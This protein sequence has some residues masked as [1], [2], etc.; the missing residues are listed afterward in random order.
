MNHSIDQ[1]R[2]G[3]WDPAN[4]NK[5]GVS[6]LVYGGNQ[7]AV[8][9][10]KNALVAVKKSSMLQVPDRKQPTSPR[11][12]PVY[13][14]VRIPIKEDRF[15]IYSR[16]FAFPSNHGAASDSDYPLHSALILFNIALAHHL[17]AQGQ[18]GDRSLRDAAYFYT[19]SLQI[20]G[21]VEL[22]CGKS[23]VAPIK[24][25]ALNNLA[26]IHY[27]QGSARKAHAILTETYEFLSP[28]V[29]G[30]HGQAFDQLDFD[31]LTLNAVMM[32]WTFAA[33]CA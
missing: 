5:Q 6:W 9:S 26:V 18:V 11:P 1:N 2:A 7:E 10:F 14:S 15:Y 21:S 8:M 19:M 31:G 12:N 32:K 30:N 28:S 23:A 13:A 16:A 17:R 22:R 3:D 24:L 20:L 27:E 4:L 33:G 25:A 29:L